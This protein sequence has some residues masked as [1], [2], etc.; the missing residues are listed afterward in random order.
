MRVPTL[1][2]FHASA[3][4][5]D[6]MPIPIPTPTPMA[7]FSRPVAAKSRRT[8][9]PPFAAT[10]RSRR[11][12]VGFSLDDSQCRRG[13]HARAQRQVQYQHCKSG[14]TLGAMDSAAVGAVRGRPPDAQTTDTHTDPGDSELRCPVC[15]SMA[16][17]HQIP[18]HRS[19]PPPCPGLFPRPDTHDAATRR[20]SGSRTNKEGHRLRRRTGRLH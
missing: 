12:V 18:Q 2:L 1:G 11:K 4:A 19:Y 15:V 9:P 5:P 17:N 16:P 13:D 10:F 20:R 6:S 14:E 3:R 7:I 8:F